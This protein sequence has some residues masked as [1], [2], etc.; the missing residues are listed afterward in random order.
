MQITEEMVNKSKDYRGSN[1]Q[2]QWMMIRSLCGRNAK[3]G[4]L[5]GQH[6]T[7]TWWDDFEE[8]GKKRTRLKSS[9]RD[10]FWRP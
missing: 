4:D 1:S 3:P 6:V 9:Y 10:G 5:V 2:R 8:A 7:T